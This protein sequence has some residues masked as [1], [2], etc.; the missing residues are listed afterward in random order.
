MSTDDFH[1]YANEA[2]VLRIDHLEIENRLD[3]LTLTGDLVLTRDRAGLAL[4]Q[5]LQALLAR[6]I[7]TLQADPDLPERM[8]TVPVRITNAA[9]DVIAEEDSI[10]VRVAPESYSE[11]E[12]AFED[13]GIAPESSELSMV[14]KNLTPVDAAT[15]RKVMTLMENLEENEDVQNVY[16]TADFTD[17][18]MEELG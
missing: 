10:E 17:E 14:P 2:Y 11:V 13:A 5:E 15:A 3:H 1:P 7:H 8:A 16:V 9:D 4:A 6:A 18:I 12:K